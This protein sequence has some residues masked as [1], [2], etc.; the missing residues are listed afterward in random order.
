MRRL[1]HLSLLLLF[2]PFAGR[3]ADFYWAALGIGNWSDPA[4]WSTTAPA[5]TAATSLPGT[6][7]RVIFR[8][9]SGGRGTGASSVDIPFTVDKIEILASA[10]IVLLIE[11]DLTLNSTIDGEGFNMASANSTVITSAT[12]TDLGSFRQS[13]GQFILGGNT[14]HIIDGD[15]YM[16]GLMGTS[17]AFILNFGN[18]LVFR[19][20]FRLEDPSTFAASNNTFVRFEKLAS[21]T[22]PTVIR[23]DQVSTTNLS[24][25]D[26]T[27][28][29]ASTTNDIVNFFQNTVIDIRRNLQL[30]TG[31][32][33]KGAAF[34]GGIRLFGNLS[35]A[36]GGLAGQSTA[37]ITFAGSNAQ[38]IN[39]VGSDND[40]WNGPITFN[41]TGGA[42]TLTNTLIANGAAQL[43]TFTSGI[44]NT[45]SSAILQMGPT[46]LATGFSNASHVNGPVQKAGPANF[47]FPIGNG[48]VAAPLLISGAGT[49]TDPLA[50]TGTYIAQY[51]SVDPA[52]VGM[53]GTSVT[54][55]LTNAS[56][57]E[58]WTLSKIAG[59]AGGNARVWLSYENTRSCGVTDATALR[60]AN[61]PVAGSA[62]VN[63][64]N[65][66]S[67]QY[68]AGGFTFVGTATTQTSYPN[69]T[70][71]SIDATLNP[72]PVNW[73]NFTGRYFEGKVDLNWET[74]VEKDNDVYSVERSATGH[75]FD[76]IGTVPGRGTT[77][78]RSSYAFTDNNPL[79]G[80]NYY[81]IKQTD[82]DGKFTYSSVIRVIATNGTATGL[83]LFPNPA[84]SSQQVTLENT[85]LRNKKVALTIV[86]SNGV[87]VRQEQVTFGN[88]SR[89][90]VNIS[91]LKKG[92]YFIRISDGDK[93]LVSPV[94]VQ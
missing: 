14:T 68:S 7:D 37:A 59:G 16:S 57:C 72:L 23:V 64:S 94:V 70:L 33:N 75:G 40:K 83:R 36:G 66:P 61:W 71:A 29:S 2:L 6:G 41:K 19:S 77:S 53:P 1:L 47:T 11:S 48:T 35:S 17:T 85:T 8:S 92:S 18:T 79:D 58:Y 25:Y 49:S 84:I 10:A 4:S 3:A 55:P 78:L 44:L 82:F 26:V 38:T 69:F 46:A 87:V 90:K 52:T 56:Q 67:D 89:L 13:R 9:M 22:T 51:F 31:R 62:W 74:A 80:E 24:F 21:H 15:F 32:F 34:S 60:V 65:S 12:F 88:D 81:R 91:N 5:Y 28:N 73:L 86:S 39:L 42:V 93:K 30:V 43:I 45:T 50:A 76:A 54:A 27:L 63:R 20:N